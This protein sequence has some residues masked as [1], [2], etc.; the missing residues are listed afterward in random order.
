MLTPDR[1]YQPDK[2]K[3]RLGN[4]G[5]VGFCT[6]WNEPE[7]AVKRAPALID[8]CAIVGTLY[9]RQGVSIIVRNLALNPQIRRLYLWGF[10]PLSNTKFGKTG[11]DVLLAL[12]KSG[13]EDDGTVVGTNFKLE[14][15]IEVAV[16]RKVV[17]G[18]ELIDLSEK[19]LDDA[20]AAVAL[21]AT[22]PYMEPV[23]FPDAVTRAP[24][25]FPS[26]IVGWNVRGKG[27]ID[28]W[29]RVVQRIM[30]YGTVKGTQYGMPQREL[31]SVGWVVREEDPYHPALP[32]DWPQELREITGAS[33][34]GIHEYLPVILSPEAQPG[35]AYTYGNR[36]KSYP[37]PGGGTLDQIADVIIKQF[38]SS[39]DSRR[40]AATTLVPP[41]DW[42]SKEPPCLTEVQCL[43]SDG[44]L[45]LMSSFRS[46]DI[47]K[48]AIPNAFGLRAL[49]QE[50]ATTC[51]FQMGCLQITSR[52]AHIYEADWENAKKL[53]ACSFTEREPSLVF[54]AEDA[55]PRGNFT[56]RVT[57]EGIEMTM[58]GPDGAEL[59]K[60]TGKSA[61]Y[62]QAWLAQMD[63]VSQTG[64]ALDIG[65]ELQKAHI[66]MEKG[67][68]YTQDR[69]LQL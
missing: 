56:I 26:E 34:N 19:P 45:H 65:M 51:G 50:I 12:W 21:G 54:K 7:V 57:P 4:G 66:A 62:L 20:A 32:T 11:T 36:L 35:T 41:V 25:R 49:Q 8:N 30:L 39:P 38:K 64:H 40:T 3:V 15:E 31:I 16:A 53:V 55:D 52:S 43:Q 9:G 24:E 14:P 13:V 63:L 28:A 22:D 10:G 6:V 42:D 61:R 37:M 33:E 2:F 60:K 17:A 68:P 58:M 46:H 69:P 27:I 47:F 1:L 23:R 67:V 18:V 48:A 59:M 44:Y 29:L 5:H